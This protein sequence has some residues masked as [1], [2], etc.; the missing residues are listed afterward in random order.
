VA[1]LARRWVRYRSAPLCR[2]LGVDPASADTDGA[3][4][5][6]FG[7]WTAW[8]APRLAMGYSGRGR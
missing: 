6:C 4:M 5:E 2:R 1:E 7:V 8:P 3:L